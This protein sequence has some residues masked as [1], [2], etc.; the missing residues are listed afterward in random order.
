[1]ALLLVAV[2][3]AAIV[4]VFIDHS[5][6]ERVEGIA[7]GAAA[8]DFEVTALSGEKVKLADYRGKRVLLNFW[9]SWCKPCVREMPLLNELHQSPDSR[10]E[11]LFINVGES[12]GTVSEYLNE[13]RFSFPV[14][15][16]VTG[17]ISAAYGVHALP[18]TFIINEEGEISKI[19]LGEIDDF[20]LLQQW[21]ADAKL[22]Q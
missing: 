10:I 14:A 17:T 20:S 5:N 15:I 1:M 6:Q 19:R 3:A 22:T 8:P 16:D 21:L 7:E 12:R 13:H 2:I 9:A 18:A 11:T 4:W